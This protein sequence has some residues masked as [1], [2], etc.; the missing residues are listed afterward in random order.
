MKTFSPIAAGLLLAMNWHATAETKVDFSKDIQPI[1]QQ[2]CVKCHG[3]EKQKGKLRLD[4]KDAAFKGGKDG[5]VIVA[6][7]AGKKELDK[8]VI[9]PKSNDDVMPNQREPP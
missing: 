2:T 7:A 6:G 4:S 1:L 9:L 3:P 5:V 8:S